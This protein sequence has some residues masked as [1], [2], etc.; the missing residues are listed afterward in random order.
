MLLLT[1]VACGRSLRGSGRQSRTTH[2]DEQRD[3]R[4]QGKRGKARDFS[5][6]L[7]PVHTL[8]L[9]EAKALL[10][11]RRTLIYAGNVPLSSHLA[12][13]RLRF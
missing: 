2:G 12:S 13:S 4:D 10:A 11:P 8:D 7:Q 9:K 6:N 5:R 1:G 3:S